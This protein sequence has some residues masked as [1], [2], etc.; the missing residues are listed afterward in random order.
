MRKVRKGDRV[1]VIAG[2]ERGKTGKVLVVLDEKNRIIVE[3]INM[4]TK[5]QRATQNL[6]EPGIIK[7]E[8]PIHIS[9][10]LPVCPECDKPT[11]IA[12]ADVDGK[13]MRQCK[14]CGETFE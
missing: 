10:V 9:N 3:N 7:R 6:R 5:H 12:F 14:Q 1:Q 11:R 4:I 13:K 2:D 8:G